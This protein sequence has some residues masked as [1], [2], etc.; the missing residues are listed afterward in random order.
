MK[1]VVE[2]GRRHD[3]SD[4]NQTGD[5]ALEFILGCFVCYDDFFLLRGGMLMDLIAALEGDGLLTWI[6][7]VAG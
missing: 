6:V 5:L 4:S 1:G 3:A 2:R 7:R